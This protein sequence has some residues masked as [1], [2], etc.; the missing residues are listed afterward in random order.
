MH[1]FITWGCAMAL[2][3]TNME[4]TNKLITLT[5]LWKSPSGGWEILHSSCRP[6]LSQ[7]DTLSFC[8]KVKPRQKSE[9]ISSSGI[10]KGVYPILTN[11]FSW[12]PPKLVK[13]FCFPFCCSCVSCLLPNQLNRYQIILFSCLAIV[14]L[15][16][17]AES[18]PRLLFL[19]SLFS[20][21]CV[22]SLTL[23]VCIIHLPL[24]LCEF[25]VHRT[26]ES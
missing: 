12:L 4:K 9:V 24:V 18:F 11:Y 17:Q 10:Q 13:L 6:T 20:Q 2:S 3:W 8:V 26:I 15:P 16:S 25:T 19:S 14:S 21:L 22:V 5:S 23:P 7:P 1:K